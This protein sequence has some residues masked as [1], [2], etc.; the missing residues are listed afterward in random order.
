MG[1]R[2][3][4]WIGLGAAAVATCPARAQTTFRASTT[5]VHVAFTARDA[6]GQLVRDLQPADLSVFEDGA[7]CKIAYFSRMQQVPLSLGLLLDMSPSQR[8]RLSQH[9]KDLGGFLNTLLGPSDRA[10]LVGFGD[11]LRLLGDS[12]PIGATLLWDLSH[13]DRKYTY[14]ELGPA[15]A[16]D[17][18]TALFDAVFYAVTTKLDRQPG[19]RVLV[20][21]SDGEDNSSANDEAN[22]LAAAED[23]D[24]TIYAVR[25]TE[26][27]RL[28]ARDQYGVYVMERLGQATGGRAIDAAQAPASV[29]LPAIADELHSSYELG[30]YAPS[31]APGFRTIRVQSLRPGVQVHSRSGYDYS[32]N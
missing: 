7:P 11:H 22:A 8:H 5:L 30:Y 25:Y 19:R 28:E 14:P 1:A 32:G 16:R 15:L 21:F 18:G 2:H 12:T 3:W 6:S 10:F 26:N 4:I 29:Y 23:N 24:V 27:R 20:I 13:F 9:Q 31:G 17:G